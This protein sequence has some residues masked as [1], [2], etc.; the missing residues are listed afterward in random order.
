MP[1]YFILLLFLDAVKKKKIQRFCC[2]FAFTCSLFVITNS[3]IKN[4][5]YLVNNKSQ[6]NV[7][8]MEILADKGKK[9]MP[10]QF[11]ASLNKLKKYSSC[12]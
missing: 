3:K 9:L 6:N 10:A 11:K 1:F 7:P 8:K 5:I 4:Y 2:Q 12:P